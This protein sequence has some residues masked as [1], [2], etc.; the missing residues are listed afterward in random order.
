M[1]GPDTYTCELDR[2]RDDALDADE[3]VFTPQQRG[4]ILQSVS[5][6]TAPAIDFGHVID[7]A[8]DS[9]TTDQLQ[10]RLEFMVEEFRAARQRR[11]VKQGVALW[12]R[13]AALTALAEEPP[14]PEKPN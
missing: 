11:L 13:T 5:F 6:G 9:E 10:A 4:G 2:M 3:E 7:M 12:N 8:N 14:T 1:A